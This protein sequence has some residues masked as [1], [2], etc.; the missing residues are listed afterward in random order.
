MTI[1]HKVQD[2]HDEHPNCPI[3]G[4]AVGKGLGLSAKERHEVGCWNILAIDESESQRAEQRKQRKRE[5]DRERARRKREGKHV[6]RAEY[7]AQA[8]LRR[9]FCQEHRISE[10]TLR[11]RIAKDDPRVRSLSHSDIFLK[12]RSDRL[13]TSVAKTPMHRQRGQNIGE[14]I[15]ASLHT[16]SS[17]TPLDAAFHPADGANEQG[18]Q[19]QQYS[20]AGIPPSLP[21]SSCPAGSV[22]DA[23]QASPTPEADVATAYHAVACQAAPEYREPVQ[24]TFIGM[25]DDTTPELGAIADILAYEGG[26]IPETVVPVLRDK[27]KRDS[28]SQAKM[29]RRLGVSQ[30]HYANAERRRSG[31]SPKRAALFRQIVTG[32]V[33]VT[34]PS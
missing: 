4:E 2:W 34:S 25:L 11:R 26:I 21:S 1:I 3:S 17:E 32:E 14:T 29:A 24:M 22:G 6:P 20:P 16:A 28:I 18:F 33:K 12:Q 15:S 31:L 10:R 19:A 30:P 23:Q 7:L 9:A 5:A 13:R 27:R 8:E